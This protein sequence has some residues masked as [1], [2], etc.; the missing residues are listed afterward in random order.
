MSKFQ[1]AY[2]F[3]DSVM[4]WVVQTLIAVATIL[5]FALDRFHLHRAG[6]S[7]SGFSA[8]V[9]R[10]DKSMAKFF[11]LYASVNG[12][13]VA[14]SLSITAADNYRV[15]LSIFDTACCFYI[16]VLNQFMRNKIV[17]LTSNLTKVESR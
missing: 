7:K 16:F 14:F 11:S 2:I 12:L 6:T 5:L 15:I 4:F 8:S 1:I 9:I 3:F 13:L 10:G 17:E